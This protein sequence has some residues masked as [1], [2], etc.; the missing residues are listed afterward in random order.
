MQLGWQKHFLS[1]LAAAN[2]TVSC[3]ASTALTNPDKPKTHQIK[4]LPAV[5]SDPSTF[6]TS[7]WFDGVLN[8]NSGWPMGSANLDTSSDQRYMSALGSKAY[9]AAVSPGFFT[10]YSP[11]TYNKD[12][13]YRGDNWLYSTRWEDII[14]M[15]DDFD[16]V[17]IL[18]WNGESLYRP[19]T[20][21]VTDQL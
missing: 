21:A 20:S 12:W 11:N 3:A 10:Y 18:T 9:M 16:M 8:W 2:V 14:K 5:F 17:E 6:S 7:T 1:P 4:F 19:A 13:I 15:R